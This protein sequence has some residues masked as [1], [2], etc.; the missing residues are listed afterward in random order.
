MYNEDLIK[1]HIA[2][3]YSFNKHE[4][5][6]GQ[7]RE[8]RKKEFPIKLYLSVRNWRTKENKEVYLSLSQMPVVE[9]EISMD[10]LVEYSTTATMIWGLVFI[11]LSESDG[12]SITNKLF[13]KECN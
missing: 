9:I 11:F 6:E 12:Y 8:K 3:K 7:K 2:L 10:T 4:K 5:G 1:L 13:F